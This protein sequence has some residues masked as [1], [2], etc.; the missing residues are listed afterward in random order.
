[1]DID[2]WRNGF[3]FG[4]G[5]IKK[6]YEKEV[7]VSLLNNNDEEIMSDINITPLVDI[8]LVLLITFMLVSTLVDFSAIKVELP[9]AATGEDAKIE[10]IA[11]V[12]TK[13]GQYFVAGNPVNSFDELKAILTAKKER[14]PQIQTVI[15]ADKNVSH[16]HVVKIIDL[17]RKLGIAKFAISVEL[18]DE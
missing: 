1:L 17:V 6:Y 7:T 14:N 8:M 18:S 11:I 16:G 10:S 2:D 9:K 12:I 13:A 5:F 4:G 15:S 3:R